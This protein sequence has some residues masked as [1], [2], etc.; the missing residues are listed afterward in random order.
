MIN[1]TQLNVRTLLKSL[2]WVKFSLYIDSKFLSILFE[3]HGPKNQNYWGI[4]RFS[5]LN[6][7][8]NAL[9][10]SGRKYN[11]VSSLENTQEYNINMKCKRLPQSENA[12]LWDIITTILECFSIVNKFQ[13]EDW[14]QQPRKKQIKECANLSSV[15]IFSACQCHHAHK[16][17]MMKNRR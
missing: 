4:P 5:T 17:K 15:Q 12:Q 16:A 1:K 2:F 9:S 14:I 8:W 3:D 13:I 10:L 6:G 11:C 7:K